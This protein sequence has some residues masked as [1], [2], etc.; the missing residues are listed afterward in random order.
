SLSLLSQTLTE[1]TQE[2]AVRLRS[3]AVCSDSEVGKKRKKDDDAV[4]T[5]AHE[6][7]FP[8]T[9][10]PNRLAAE[11][12][13]VHDDD[14]M[15][16]VFATY[17][18]IDVIHRAQHEFKLPAFD[19]ILCD[20][21][22]RTTGATFE[23]QEESTFVRVHDAAY[24]QG[25]K[26]LYMTATPRIFGEVAKATAGKDS[27]TLCSMDDPALFGETL[28]V[29]TFSAAVQRKLLVDYKV[30]V[31]AVEEAHVN[32][33][34]QELLKD[35]NNELRVDDA[36]KIVG[37]WKALAKQ[38][39]SRDL[40]DDAEPMKR[41][42][43]FCQV[44]RPNPQARSPKVASTTIQKMF[45]AVVEAYRES[46][47][48]EER[49]VQLRCE[50]EHIDGGMNASQKE[51]KIR[52]LKEEPPDHT[53]RVLSNVRCLSEG[54]DV[55]A[56]D[57]V[58]FLTP[59]N[60]QVDVVQ[61]VG[62]VMRVTPGKQRGY[63]VLPV[64]I[65]PNVAPHEALNDNETYRVVWQVLQALRS[66]DDRFDAMINKLELTGADPRKMEVIAVTDT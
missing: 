31:L 10:Q 45:S 34:I 18:S 36:A 64:V 5:F 61:S 29:L 15:T 58:L 51:A 8:A 52:W 7:Q 37:C 63:V 19:L 40:V 60:S 50:A 49:S 22:H 66:H 38:G 42:V 12:N 30:I 3:F 6:L 2:S 55:P 24:I 11:L 9:T 4:Q 32:R 53:C 17:H 62:R 1:W 23:D 26:R 59:R 27:V 13:R 25:A 33:R 57:A 54:V 41:A 16:V 65:P 21:A 46:A 47:P 48:E 28:H 44:I 35:K 14:P 39:L 43:A 20:E 56:L